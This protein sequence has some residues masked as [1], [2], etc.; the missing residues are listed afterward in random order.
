MAWPTVT[1]SPSATL[2]VSSTPGP[3][4]RTS[5]VTLSVS[6]CAMIS[7]ASTVCPGDFNNAAIAPSVMES[8]I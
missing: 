5:M 6:I 4:A 7:S 3:G 8:P 2:Y 1:V